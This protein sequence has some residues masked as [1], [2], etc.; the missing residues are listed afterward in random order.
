MTKDL[1][2][3]QELLVSAVKVKQMNLKWLT[4]GDKNFLD[5]IEFV[6]D[7]KNRD[8][9]QTAFINSLF[10]TY[11]KVFQARIY[12]TQFVP[13]VVYLAAM[14]NFILFILTFYTEINTPTM[15]QHGMY[16]PFFAF[17][18]VMTINNIMNEYVQLQ[19]RDLI[20]YL[21]FWNLNDL[22][23][24]LSNILLL[25][26]SGTNWPLGL[27]SMKLC[28]SF[29]AFFLLLKLIDWLRLFNETAF[30]VGLMTETIKD[31]EYFVIIM[32]IWYMTFGTAFYILNLS[33]TGEQEVDEFNH[34][35]DLSASFV[36]DV[37]GFWILDAF[38]N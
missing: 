38:S 6:K 31:I 11:W 7:N 15:W 16:Y 13:F 30:F 35:E 23:Y 18:A 3:D 24:L 21:S 26:A 5:L 22:A 9:L 28:G 14:I 34:E 20:G 32:L 12:W 2:L 8:L 36:P 10:T 17:C 4:R 1:V 27:E 33:R 25:V 19:H 29:T 37:F